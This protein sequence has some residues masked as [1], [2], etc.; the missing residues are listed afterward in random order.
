MAQSGITTNNANHVHDF[1]IKDDGSVIIYEAIHP[2]ESRIRHKHQYIGKWPNGYVT[3]V[4]SNCHPECEIK[5]GV[6]GAPP[7][8]HNIQ[9]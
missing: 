7:H 3:Q 6:A 4:A 9:I 8:I 5:Y 1:I 2:D